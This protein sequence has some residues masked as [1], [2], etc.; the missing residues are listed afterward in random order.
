MNKE[1]ISFNLMC[2]KKSGGEVR[3]P[4]NNDVAR[5]GVELVLREAV[6]RSIPVLDQTGGK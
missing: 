4:Y 3:V 6:N 5:R 2:E 1:R